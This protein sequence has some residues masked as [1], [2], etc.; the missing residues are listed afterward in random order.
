MDLAAARRSGLFA[1][2]F[3]QHGVGARNAGRSEPE[4]DR[5]MDLQSA[6]EIETTKLCRPGQIL[7]K[8]DYDSP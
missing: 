5:L 4:P 3:V 7:E 8:H 2:A 6:F 1:E